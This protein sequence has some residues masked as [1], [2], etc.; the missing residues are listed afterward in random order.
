MAVDIR[1]DVNMGMG[2]NAATLPLLSGTATGFTIDL[3]KMLGM[4]SLAN[5]NRDGIMSMGT[6]QQR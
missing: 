4:V 6:R 5:D 2:D 3:P 1:I